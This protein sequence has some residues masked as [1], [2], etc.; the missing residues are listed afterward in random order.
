MAPSVSTASHRH[1]E[2]EPS[3]DTT[4]I[5]MRGWMQSLPE[6]LESVDEAFVLW[7]EQGAVTNR[8]IVCGPTIRHTVGLRDN[9]VRT[10]SF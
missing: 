9:R 1:E 7:W 2:V 3:W 6:Y 4:Q 8:H 5:Y 10:Y